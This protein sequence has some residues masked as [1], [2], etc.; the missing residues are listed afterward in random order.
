MAHI[1][2]GWLDRGEAAHGHGRRETLIAAKNSAGEPPRYVQEE[3]AGGSVRWL[4]PVVRGWTGADDEH[5][6]GFAV[7]A[8]RAPELG[9]LA[10]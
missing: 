6:E 4:A 1:G 8:N 7:A 10:R 9:G 2:L 5:A 3:R